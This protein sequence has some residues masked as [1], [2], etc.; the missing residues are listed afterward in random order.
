[1]LAEDLPR[2]E[3]DHKRRRSLKTFNERCP[4]V[5]VT[6]NRDKADFVVLLDHE[7]GKQALQHRNK[8]AVFARD[9]DA[10]FSNSTLSLGG[11]VKDACEAIK[12]RPLSPEGEVGRA[13]RGKLTSGG[14]LQ[15]GAVAVISTPETTEIQV[16]GVFVGNTPATLKLGEGKHSIRLSCVGYRDWF[17]ELFVLAG[18]DV[19]LNAA[20]KKND[21]E[22]K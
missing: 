19:R 17:K 9:G 13:Q 3:L 8:I 20:L 22:P 6:N 12:S 1:V 16:D 7:G 15:P 4:E 11:A 18:S 2:G 14:I 21:E 5:V 10:I